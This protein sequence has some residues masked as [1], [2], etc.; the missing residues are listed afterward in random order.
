MGGV[1]KLGGGRSRRRRRRGRSGRS[2]RWAVVA[3]GLSLALSACNVVYAGSWRTGPIS[4]DGDDTYA[5]TDQGGGI[6]FEAPATNLGGNLRF[7]GYDRNIPESVDHE[8]C[9]TWTGSPLTGGTLNRIQPGVALRAEVTVDRRRAITVSNNV[10]FYLR[11]TWNVH[12]ADSTAQQPMRLLAQLDFIDEMGDWYEPTSPHSPPWRMCARVVG[13]DLAVR[14]WP[15]TLV[16]EPAWDDPLYARSVSLD[17]AYVFA[18]RPGWYMAHLAPG[19]VTS[20][21]DWSGAGPI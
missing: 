13:T 3:V 17:P 12:Y 2:G 20:L 19:E 7:L 21:V 8:S 6:G 1:R 11:G 14:I 5:M 10:F 16:A 4:A 9:T 15:T 18:G